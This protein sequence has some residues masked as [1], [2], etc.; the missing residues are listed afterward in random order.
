MKASLWIII[1]IL[2]AILS[3]LVGYGLA[4][5]EINIAGVPAGGITPGY[6]GGAG[7][8]GAPAGGYGSPAGG[9][10][11]PAGG[12]GAPAGGYGAPPSGGYGTH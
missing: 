6:G 2:V 3:F 10:G 5:R 12:Y 9:Y 7:G 8:Y 1:I 4:P 11:V